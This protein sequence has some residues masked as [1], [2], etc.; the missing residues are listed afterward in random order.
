MSETCFARRSKWK[1]TERGLFY[2]P[3]NVES[4]PTRPVLTTYR[5]EAGV[6]IG[7]HGKYVYNTVDTAAPV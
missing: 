2:P 1:G 5:M 6:R 3:V 7:V 4:D